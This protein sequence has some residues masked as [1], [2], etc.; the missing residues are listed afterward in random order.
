[1]AV[2]KNKMTEYLDLWMSLQGRTFRGYALATVER[3]RL[4]DPGVVVSAKTVHNVM[5]GAVR[6][7]AI[8]NAINDVVTEFDASMEF[9]KK[10]HLK[11][12]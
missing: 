12:A 9:E 3:L 2:A 7:W 10:L 5:T 8:L 1:M 11:S 6:D 4:T